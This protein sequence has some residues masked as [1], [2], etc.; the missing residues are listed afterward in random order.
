MTAIPNIKALLFIVGSADFKMQL[1]NAALLAELLQ[2]DDV[3]D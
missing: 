2:F 1:F 3:S